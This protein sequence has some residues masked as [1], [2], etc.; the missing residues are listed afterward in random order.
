MKAA[1]QDGLLK[2]TSSVCAELDIDAG[3]VD[4]A[5]VLDLAKDVHHTV[6][7]P[8]ESISLYLLGVAVGQGMPAAEA[9]ARVAR[10]ARRWDG[11]DLDWRD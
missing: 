10:L 2:W 6:R 9:A 1:H 3:E 5:L 8:A 4:C 11:A 7:K